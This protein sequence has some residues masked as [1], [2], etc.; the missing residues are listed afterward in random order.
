MLWA[1]SRSSLGLQSTVRSCILCT[2]SELGIRSID[3]S[4]Q[5]VEKAR[6]LVTLLMNADRE[7]Y[8]AIGDAVVTQELH[9]YSLYMR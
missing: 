5:S 2:E 3:D 7:W 1:S 4:P 9:S 8:V 6:Y